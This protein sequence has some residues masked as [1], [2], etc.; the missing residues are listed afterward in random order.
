[1]SR[2]WNL[3]A[4]QIGP[5]CIR[6]TNAF[7]ARALKSTK[8]E[9][10]RFFRKFI[11]RSTLS[12]CLR[13]GFFGVRNT[14]GSSTWHWEGGWTATYLACEASPESDTL[15]LSNAIWLSGIVQP[16]AFRR[17]SQIFFY[18]Q[19]LDCIGALL[20]AEQSSSQSCK[21]RSD[22]RRRRRKLLFAQFSFSSVQLVLAPFV[23]AQHE[24]AKLNKK[25]LHHLRLS[26]AAL[27]TQRPLGT[28]HCG[29]NAAFNHPHTLAATKPCHTAHYTY[30]RSIVDY[31]CILH[32]L[33]PLLVLFA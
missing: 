30:V 20:C 29:H 24:L 18:N 32:S 17:R 1:M 7:W 28:C 3:D 13:E 9:I 5:R 4:A 27:P 10:L 22:R 16:T 11:A 23:L 25:L 2:A 14:L 8:L 31:I 33:D 12:R 21:L 6:R 19:T 26:K 15:T